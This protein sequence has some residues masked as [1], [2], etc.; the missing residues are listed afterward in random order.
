MSQ[1]AFLHCDLDAFFASVEQ[2]DNPQ[3]KGK[4]VIVGGTDEKRSVVCTASYEARQFG[5][6]SAMPIFMAKRL[7]P[8]GIFLPTRMNRYKE[9]SVQIMEIFNSYSPDIQQMS[10]DEAFIDLTG[11]EKLFGKFEDTAKKLKNEVLQK[12]GLTISVG[13]ASNKY[14]AKIASGMSKPDGLFIVPFGE[15]EKFIR[16]LPLEKLWGIGKKTLEKLHSKYIRTT[17]Q[18]FNFS[19]ENLQLNFGKSTGEFLYNA[20]RGKEYERFNIESKTHSISNETTF[21][22]D[23]RNMEEI[24]KAM[25]QLCKSVMK[26]VWKENAISYT[27]S[28]KIRYGDFSTISISKTFD[29]NFSSANDLFE[30]SLNLFKSR[31]SKEKGL[32]LLGIALQNVIDEKNRIPMLFEEEP[33]KYSKIEKAIF[34]LEEKIPGIKI[35]SASSITLS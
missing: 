13:L 12:T 33:D 14:V 5:V 31:F 6:H 17:E 30:K 8:N 35:C 16:S 3:L 34:E 10:I 26:R 27:V 23:L 32:R 4:P 21:A 9:K 1:K 15:E 29:S 7:C 22:Y 24:K 18:L 2:L 11:T 28:V 20:A 19:L 25:Y